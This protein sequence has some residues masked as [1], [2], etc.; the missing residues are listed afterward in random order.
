MHHQYRISL[1][2][3]I[4]WSVTTYSNIRISSNSKGYSNIRILFI[5][6]G[7][8]SCKSAAWAAIQG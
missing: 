2:I 4:Y 6:T 3:N 1:K 5:F 7:G 8:S